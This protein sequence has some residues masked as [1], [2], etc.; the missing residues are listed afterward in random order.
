M[1]ANI[2]SMEANI[3]S[4]EANMD[5][6]EAIQRRAARF[7]LRRNRNTSRVS[8][9]IDVLRWPSLQDR[10]R[11]AR[12][13][14]LYTIQ[15]ELVCTNNMTMKLQPAVARQRKGHTYQYVQP[16]CRTQYQQQ[17]FLPRTIQD[18]NNLP[19]STVEATTIDTF[20]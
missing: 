17:S 3:D 11:A 13:T 2:D 16:R 19:Q 20:V 18:W 1:E 7:V 12:L 10:R 15:H 9:M 5:S 6:M 8:K 14:M 4:M